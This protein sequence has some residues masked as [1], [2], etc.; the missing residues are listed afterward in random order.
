MPIMLLHQ[1]EKTYSRYKRQH[2]PTSGKK[3]V[4]KAS[5]VDTIV[6]KNEGGP[7]KMDKK[8]KEKTGAP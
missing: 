5:L 1:R 8:Y 2:N 6:S 7:E 4:H 3:L